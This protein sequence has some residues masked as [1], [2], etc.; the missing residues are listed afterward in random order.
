MA[1]S[2][3]NLPVADSCIPQTIGWRACMKPNDERGGG[4]ALELLL[5]VLRWPWFW[6]SLSC[7]QP[8]WG[9]R[10]KICKSR[11]RS[12]IGTQCGRPKG[13]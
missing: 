4:V 13:Y 1:S 2:G 8:I 5:Q 11:N 10:S 3:L 6:Q 9:S 7:V 12:I